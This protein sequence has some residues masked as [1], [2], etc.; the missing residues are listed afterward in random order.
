MVSLEMSRIDSYNILWLKYVDDVDLSQHCMKC[1]IGAKSKKVNPSFWNGKVDLDESNSEY[2]YLCGVVY[3]WDWVKNFHCAFRKKEGA[4][5]EY[6]FR[7]TWIKVENAEQVPI[8]S[9]NIDMTNIKASNRLYST[10]RNWQFANWFRKNVKPKCKKT[11]IQKFE[12][13]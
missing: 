5:F 2:F 6:K 8:S 3:P 7:D 1:L 9:N 11:E 13:F 10:C 4:S 12:L